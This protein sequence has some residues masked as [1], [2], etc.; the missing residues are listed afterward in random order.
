[1][2]IYDQGSQKERAEMMKSEARLRHPSQEPPT[3]RTYFGIA[4]TPSAEDLPRPS[5]QVPRL[6]ASS[7]WSRDPTGIEP[8][9]GVA[10]DDQEPTGTPAEI[11]R[12]LGRRA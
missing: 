6:P 7:P 8:P 12:S 11:A 5:L 9:F 3:P 2:S 4:S 10:I 1:M